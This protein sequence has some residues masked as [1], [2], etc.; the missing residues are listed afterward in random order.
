MNN[1]NTQN[2]LSIISG[3]ILLSNP[4]LNIQNHRYT[5]QNNRFNNLVHSQNETSSINLTSN[6]NNELGNN[7]IIENHHNDSNN[8]SNFTLTL[9][10]SENNKRN[11]NYE[12]DDEEEEVDEEKDNNSSIQ[13]SNIGYHDSLNVDLDSSFVH[14]DEIFN[15][16]FN[17]PPIFVHE[18]RTRNNNNNNEIIHSKRLN[19]NNLAYITNIQNELNHINNIINDYNNMTMRDDKKIKMKINNFKKSN[20]IK[21]HRRV[22]SGTFNPINDFQEFKYSPTYIHLL[23]SYIYSNNL[24]L[25]KGEEHFDLE[26]EKGLK[27]CQK[28]LR[29]IE[30]LMMSLKLDGENREYRKKFTKSYFDLFNKKKL[31]FLTEILGSAQETTPNIIVNGVEY[32][33]TK[34][35]LELGNNLINSFCS[36]IMTIN[37]VVKNIRDEIFYKNINK[38]KEDLKIELIE[39]DKKWV[40]YEA[41]YIFELIEIEK[42][43]KK[44]IIDAINVEKELTDYEN[45]FN[46]KGKLIINDKIYNKL[47]EKFLESI[48][49]LNQNANVEGKGRVD[50][51]IEILLH[52]EKV[53]ITVSENQSK[54]M[55]NL[56]YKVKN[57]VTKI[58]KLLREYDKNIE[59]VDPQIKNNEKLV[60]LLL[61][62]ENKWEQGKIYLLDQTKYNQ[63]LFFS[64]VIEII[65]EKYSQFSIRELIENNDPSIFISLPSLLLLKAIY[66]EDYNICQD[67]I[68]G[69][70]DKNTESGKLYFELKSAKNGIKKNIK[71]KNKVYN[72]LEKLIL[73]E[74]TKEQKDIEGEINQYINEDM[75]KNIKNG[76][77]NLSMHLQRYKPTEWNTFFELA[78]D[79]KVLNNTGKKDDTI[80]TSSK[81]SQYDSITTTN[82]YSDDFTNE[83]I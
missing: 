8:L 11:E 47:R 53:L 5:N 30:L 55:R 38:T 82:N 73:F 36:L 65:C 17:P 64:Q 72:L 66:K 67:Y 18:Y 13:P 9:E 68:T 25:F 12:E 52:A 59:E 45:K 81:I 79:I 76:L 83:N 21:K 80:I 57:S 3:P 46:M 10:I 70:Y 33:L 40:K 27:A 56:A 49:N 20:K 78:M 51:P 58:R 26:S 4:L 31:G 41:K 37:E 22:K 48:L 35:V 34:E 14:S 6:I 24:I 44:I 28:F 29:Q 75:R 71:D 23:K 43:S 74:N 54:G 15:S 7:V 63:L 16:D 32:G 69:L 39:F 77:T 61:N 42:K 60:K 1:N 62:F 19:P 2:L 50:L